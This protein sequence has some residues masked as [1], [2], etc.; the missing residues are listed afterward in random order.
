MLLIQH[1]SFDEDIIHI[2]TPNKNYTGW[3]IGIICIVNVIKIFVIQN[4]WSNLQLCM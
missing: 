2:E 3:F 1:V 4:I